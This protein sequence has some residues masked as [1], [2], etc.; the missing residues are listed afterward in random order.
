M[1]IIP[2]TWEEVEAGGSQIQGLSKWH[3]VPTKI[4][5]SFQIGILHNNTDNFSPF[6]HLLVVYRSCLRLRPGEHSPLHNIGM[7]LDIVLV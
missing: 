2:Q 1:P 4:R 7:S 3:T 5:I 6:R